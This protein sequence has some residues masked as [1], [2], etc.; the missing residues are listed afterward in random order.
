[1]NALHATQGSDD[2]PELAELMRRLEDQ[3]AEV[4]RIRQD[5][6]SKLV[7]GYSRGNEVTA[8][9]QGTGRFT[10]ISIDPEALRRYDAHD[11]GTIVAEAAND[12]LDRLAQLAAQRLSPV[13]EPGDPWP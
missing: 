8:T 12:A 11:I 6:D 2:L 7:S 10:E 13:L 1:M 4:E 3:Q 9:V 5:V